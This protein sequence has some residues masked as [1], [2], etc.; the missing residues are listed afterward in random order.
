MSSSPIDDCASNRVHIRLPTG[1]LT[2]VSIDDYDTVASVIDKICAKIHSKP[3][4]HFLASIDANGD[5]API[6]DEAHPLRSMM[7]SRRVWS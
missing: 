6:V 2:A 1:H 4:R 3:S 5:C 7:V